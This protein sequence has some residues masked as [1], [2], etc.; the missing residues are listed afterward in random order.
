VT[1]LLDNCDADLVV[2]GIAG[3]PGLMAS[4]ASLRRGMSL[5][6]AN[7]ESVVM[8]YSLLASLAEARKIAIIPVD[9]E[10]AALFQL[11]RRCGAKSIRELC[12][13]ASGGPFRGQAPGRPVDDQPGPGGGPPGMED[14]K[15]DQYRFGH[16]GQQGP[17]AY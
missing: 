9:S 3:S 7:K 15:E 8:G 5:A 17:G 6:L 16:L 13:T 2:N 12:I 4:H 1:K 11:V 10:H 14:G